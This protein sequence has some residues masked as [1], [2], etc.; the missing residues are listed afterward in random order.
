MTENAF[1]YEHI[2]KWDGLE[3]FQFLLLLLLLKE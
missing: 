2:M 1:V 3:N